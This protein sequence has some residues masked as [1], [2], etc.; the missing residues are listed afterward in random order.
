MRKAEERI[1]KPRIFNRIVIDETS[2][3]LHKSSADSGIQDEKNWYRNLPETLRW[4]HPRIYS[5][6]PNGI[7][8]EYLDYPTAHQLYMSGEAKVSEWYEIFRTA[9]T[10]QES[11]ERESETIHLS[12]EKALEIIREMYDEK[13]KARAAK[14]AADDFFK[15]MYTLDVTINGKKYISIIELADV[16]ARHTRLEAMREP[17]ERAVMIH[18]D[19]HLG[20]MLVSCEGRSLKLIDPRG[21]FG[22]L[23]G[24]GDRR[25][26]I[27]KLMHSIEGGYDLIIE[28]E[29]RL[30]YDARERKLRYKFNRNPKRH[31][32]ATAFAMVYAKEVSND[33]KLLT[34][35][36]AGLFLSM[37]PLHSENRKRQL[38]MMARAY[39][40]AERAIGM[41][42]NC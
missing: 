34:L 24:H 7:I 17:M 29:F 3:T 42:L 39:E 31:D 27:A 19:L 26:D 35:I 14:L 9:H 16:I 12:A 8:M 15:P 1:T 20:N 4:V 21:K 25:Y 23:A 6:L 22:S 28:D 38:V 18:G 41:S 11:L 5:Y 30:K 37:I 36:E 10:I 2:G 33:W 13:V 40:L 32:A